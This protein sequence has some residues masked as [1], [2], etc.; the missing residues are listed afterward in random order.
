MRGCPRGTVAPEVLAP[1]TENDASFYFPT[2]DVRTS[3]PDTPSKAFAAVRDCWGDDFVIPLVFS[4]CRRRRAS[5][6]KL[7][8]KAW[9]CHV[10]HVFGEMRLHSTVLSLRSHNRFTQGLLLSSPS[11]CKLLLGIWVMFGGFGGLGNA[12]V[13]HFGTPPSGWWGRV[14]V[15]NFQHCTMQVCLAPCSNMPAKKNIASSSVAGPSGKGGS[16][17]HYPG[18]PIELLNEREF[19]DRFCLPNA[20]PFSKRDRLVEWAEK[21]SFACLNKLFEITAVERNHH[22]LLS[23]RICLRLS[24]N[25]SRTSSTSSL[26]GYRKSWYLGA[27]RFEGP[28]FYEE[29]READ[30]RLAKSV[31]SSGGEKAGGKVEE[32]AR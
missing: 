18:K 20:F 25:L 5:R 16:G 19:H 12:L 6:S 1:S 15:S 11:S 8:E 14:T 7:S 28:S 23:P 21:A 13:R 29:A 31:L 17:C 9:E 10:E 3:V 27:L 30:G 24:E 4:L 26:G 32:S 2:K 22:M